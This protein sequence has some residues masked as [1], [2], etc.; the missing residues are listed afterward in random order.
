[1]SVPER[2]T[3]LEPL[4]STLGISDD[5]II[6]DTKH[7][8]VIP[9]AKKAWLLPTDKEYTMVLNDDILLCDG[10]LGICERIIKAMPN[11]IISLFPMQFQSSTSIRTGSK[12]TISPYVTADVL[13][14]VGIIMPTKY[15]RPCVESWVPNAICDDR[16][17]EQ[18]AKRNQIPIITTL[19]AILQHIGDLSFFNPG[20]LPIRTDF[21]EKEPVA[22]WDSTY[23]TSWT[24]LIR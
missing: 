5:K 1:M 23:V 19:P 13:S 2:L 20:R 7:L 14:G 10:F 24:N 8:G 18:W 11:A 6:I 21:F 17:I 15:A 4:K 9:T 22:D 16:S 3:Y 12:P